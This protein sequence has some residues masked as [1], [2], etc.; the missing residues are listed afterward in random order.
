MIGFGGAG[1]ARVSATPDGWRSVE[2]V[3]EQSRRTAR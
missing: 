1:E 2:L 3:E